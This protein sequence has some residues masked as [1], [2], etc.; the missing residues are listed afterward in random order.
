MMLRSI[1]TNAIALGIVLGAVFAFIEV[2]TP[3]RVSD[4]ALVAVYA[5]VLVLVVAAFLPS[6]K[7]GLLSGLL[8]IVCEP[9]GELVYY[10]L[11]YGSNIAVG[12][13]QS[14]LFLPRLVVL[15][16]SGMLG[17]AIASEFHPKRKRKT[18]KRKEKGEKREKRQL[19]TETR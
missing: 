3:A 17:G 12:M 13:L 16:L 5:V 2:S 9:I 18:R 14:I 15:P 11:V 1:R 6:I 4:I 7:W 8:V 19:P 10:S